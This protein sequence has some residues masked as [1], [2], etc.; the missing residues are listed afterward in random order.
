[1]NTVVIGV[2]A[3][4]AVRGTGCSVCQGLSDQLGFTGE[5]KKKSE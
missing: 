5:F 1:M 2:M 4:N 3:A